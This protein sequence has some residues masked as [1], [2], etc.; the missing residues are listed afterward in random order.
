MWN[1]NFTGICEETRKDHGTGNK[2][3]CETGICEETRMDHGTGKKL[4][5]SATRFFCTLIDAQNF[6]W[7]YFSAEKNDFKDF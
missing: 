5:R 1:G 4:E 6:H 7:T 2:S 3:K